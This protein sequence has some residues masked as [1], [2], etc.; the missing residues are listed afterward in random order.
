MPTILLADDEPSFR[1]L[2]DIWLRGGGFDVRLVSDGIEALASMA[3]DGLP[4]AVVLDVNMPRLSGVEL[5]RVLRRIRPL[6]PVVLVSA[7]DALADLGRSAGASAAL[8]KPSSQGELCGVLRRLIATPAADV[9]A[10]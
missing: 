9:Y 8:A 2:F 6:L 1:S 4:D 7:E 5:C 3:V 10:A